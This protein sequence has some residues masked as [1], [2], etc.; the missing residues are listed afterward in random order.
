MELDRR[1]REYLPEYANYFG[2][3]LRLNKAMYGITSFGNSFSDELTNWMI[4]EACFNHS[5]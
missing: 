2:S 4:D 1:Y 5:K 3:P